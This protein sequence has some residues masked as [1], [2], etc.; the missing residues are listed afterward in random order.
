MR[1]ITSVCIYFLLFWLCT[2]EYLTTI[3]FG[4][5]IDLFDPHLTEKFDINAKPADDSEKDDRPD[6]VDSKSTTYNYFMNKLFSILE[7]NEDQIFTSTYNYK[8]K[9]II[10]LQYGSPNLNNK[11][12]SFK[13]NYITTLKKKNQRIIASAFIFLKWVASHHTAAEILAH[14]LP[15]QTRVHPAG[16]PERHLDVLVPLLC[17]L[18]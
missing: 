7:M 12:E 11:L 13:S 14:A 2:L 15:H 4:I 10:L 16:P 6:I 5:S 8:P 17:Q 3:Q 9:W 1:K 18:S